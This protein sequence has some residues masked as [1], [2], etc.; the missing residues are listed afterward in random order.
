MEVT[1]NIPR[2]VKAFGRLWAS[3]FML[4]N[5][6]WKTGK[7]YEDDWCSFG[8]FDLNLWCEDGYL[9]VCAYLMHEDA[10]GFMTTDYNK[11]TCVV[12]KPKEQN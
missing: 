9:S 6:D 2:R 8:D 4:A 11:H 10:D 12:R 3:K 7:V 5:P 1:L